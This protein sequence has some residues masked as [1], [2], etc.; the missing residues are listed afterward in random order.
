MFVS[1]TILLHPT[2]ALLCAQQRHQQTISVKR[3]S[4]SKSNPQITSKY[5]SRCNHVFCK[6]CKVE[7]LQ[8]QPLFWLHMDEFNFL[9]P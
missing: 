3:K 5:T 9:S 8:E 4:K 1:H 2:V 7:S 6:M